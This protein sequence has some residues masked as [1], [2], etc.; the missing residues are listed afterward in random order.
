MSFANF[1]P[2]A[3]RGG[4]N[5][6]KALFDTEAIF[7]VDI[8]ISSAPSHSR[9]EFLSLL[10]TKLMTAFQLAKSLLSPRHWQKVL[11]IQL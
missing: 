5:T 8:F 2:A 9:L 7:S 1:T 11:W 6:Q 3:G 10:N 4:V